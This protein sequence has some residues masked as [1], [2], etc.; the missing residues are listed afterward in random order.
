MG[1]ADLRGFN[2]DLRGFN[3]DLRGLKTRRR[4]RMGDADLRGLKTR[5]GAYRRRCGSGAKRSD[6][7]MSDAGSMFQG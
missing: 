6:L 4:T 1:D 7:M 3:A 5:M 2:A